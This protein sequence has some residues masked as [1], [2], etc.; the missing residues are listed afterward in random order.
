MIAELRYFVP[1]SVLINI[2]KSLSFTLFNLWTPKK[3][4]VNGIL[5]VVKASTNFSKSYPY[6]GMVP[7]NVWGTERE[8]A[9]TSPQSSFLDSFL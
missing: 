4:K 5:S 8:Q 2:N 1:L 6:Q 3:R 9:V 7:D